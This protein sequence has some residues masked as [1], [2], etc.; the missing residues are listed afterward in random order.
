MM[1]K[2]T[3]TKAP[4]GPPIWVFDPPRAEITKPATMAQYRPAS[5]GTPEAMA[6]AIARGSATRPTVMPERRSARNKRFV[7]DL[8]RIWATN[9]SLLISV[10]SVPDSGELSFPE[11]LLFLGS[12]NER[13]YSGCSS[14]FHP[15]QLLV[16][17][18]VP[19]GDLT[20]VQ[21]IECGFV[22]RDQASVFTQDIAGTRLSYQLRDGSFRPHFSLPTA[23]LL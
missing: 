14:T 19:D 8:R 1:P 20:G 5:G 3:T 4:V 12:L 22:K 17:Y 11:S 15:V 10:S 9:Y 16:L 23:D 7:Y 18:P 21:P 2:T 13:F 6:K